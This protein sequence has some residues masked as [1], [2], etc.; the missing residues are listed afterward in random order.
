MFTIIYQSTK[1]A[2]YKVQPTFFG[3]TKNEEE[4]ER[5]REETRGKNT[6]FYLNFSILFN[7]DYRMKRFN[8]KQY[9]QKMQTNAL[10][11]RQ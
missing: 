8:E 2:Q 6:K 4:R 11:F 7:F 9:N 10:Y 3:S 1:D 5:G